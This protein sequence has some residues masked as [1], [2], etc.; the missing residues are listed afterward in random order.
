MWP[1]RFNWR[2]IGNVSFFIHDL[3]TSV[4]TIWLNRRMPIKRF[5]LIWSAWRLLSLKVGN[6]LWRRSYSWIHFIVYIKISFTHIFLI[7]WWS[8]GKITIAFICWSQLSKL[9][10]HLR[11]KGY[12]QKII[13]LQKHVKLHNL[14]LNGV[15]QALRKIT[16]VSPIEVFHMHLNV[17]LIQ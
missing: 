11:S 6:T 9:I 8:F 1:W 10:R 13:A 17:W 15:R 12:P 2:V 14:F 3:R 16:A 7:S 4:L 5:V